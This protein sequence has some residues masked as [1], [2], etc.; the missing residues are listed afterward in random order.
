MNSRFLIGWT[1]QSRGCN[2]GD[3]V[4]VVD[5]YFEATVYRYDGLS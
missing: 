3:V 4:A 1:A 2:V 5:D